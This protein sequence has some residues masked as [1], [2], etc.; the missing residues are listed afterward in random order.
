MARESEPENSNYGVQMSI[1][2]AL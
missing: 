1:F 2:I